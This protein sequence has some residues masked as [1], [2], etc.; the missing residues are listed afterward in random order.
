M[1]R[2][3]ITLSLIG[4][5]ALGSCTKDLEL[6]APDQFSDETFWTSE[7]NVRAYNWGFYNMFVG[8]GTGTTADFY[9]PAM[10]DDQA[11]SSFTNFPTSAAATN[12]NWDWAQIR[13]A[14]I[15][16]DRV[17][18]MTSLSQEAK[19]HWEGVARFFRAYDYFNKV[20][21]FG[22][23]PYIETDLDV[24]ET[25]IIYKPRDSRKLVIQK[26][27]EDLD[28]A[29]ANLRETDN[30]ANTLNKDVALAVKSRVALYEGTYRKYHTSLGLTADAN[31]LLTQARDAAEALMNKNKY[32]LNN[33]YVT[34]YNSMD[35]NGNKQVILYKKYIAGALTHSIIGY[36]NSTTRMNGLSKSAVESYTTANGLPITQVGGNAQYLGDD[37]IGNIR[38]NRDGRLLQTIS[39]QLMY[40]G[41]PSADGRTSSTGYRPSKFLQPASVQLAPQNETDAPL[42]NYSEVLLNYAEAA[43]ELGTLN[44]LGLDKSINL[45]RD[46]AGV[47]DLKFDGTNVMSGAAGTTIINDSKRDADVSPLI[48][49]VRRERRVELMMDGF[50]FDDIVRWRKGQYL[51]FTANP[52][53]RLGA[54]VPA[55][56]GL[57]RNADGYILPYTNVR[58]FIAPRHYLTAVPTGQITQYIPY[59]GMAQNEGW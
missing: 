22:D 49:E 3:K 54:K 25:T 50:R 58:T 39:D 35:L 23:V 38:A 8:Y 30:V 36:T 6:T 19:N 48:W 53:S 59:G 26:V 42:F 33:D 10:T 16:I 2:F 15:M 9:F 32:V 37:N 40:V 47:A 4:L 43:A 17:K 21:I 11:A 46:R 29:I 28:F 51:D 1:K 24:S 34:A 12:G 7:N 20:K 5:L 41:N 13:K 18:G 45:L 31:G 57:T 56:T 55:A 14:N 27:L 44:Q 52:D